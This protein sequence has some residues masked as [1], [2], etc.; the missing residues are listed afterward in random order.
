MKPE[1]LAIHAGYEIDSTTGAIT[2]PIHLSTTFERDLDGG[3][4]RGFVYTRDDNPNRLELERRLAALEN[5]TKA[6]A[7]A[8]SSAAFMSILQALKAGDHVIAPN[9]MYFGIQVILRE[10]F[11]DWNL[12]AS[13][14]KAAHL[15]EIQAAV[16]PNTKL[17]LIETP[18]NP[19]I[20]LTDIRGASNIAHEV[21]ALLLVDNTIASPI[22]Q[23]PFEHGAD[24]VVHA[25]TKYL[26]GHSDVLGGV[27]I[28]KEDSEFGQKL[29]RIQKIGGAVPSPFDCYLLM[30]GIFSLP[31]R[32]RAINDNALQVA[33]FLTT[34]PKIETV[35]HVGLEHHPH[36]ELGLRQ[37]SGYGGLFSFLVKGGQNEAMAITNNLK[38][39]KRATS[40]GGVHTTI[41]HRASIETGTSTPQNLLRISLGL[42]HPDDLIEDL[43]QAL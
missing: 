22:F 23:R 30:R 35:L 14:V 40:F 3:F 25:T 9:D 15:D 19:Q 12:Q 13:F 24:I 21:G 29:E 41:E 5:G 1:T 39:I 42:E 4:S 27:A 38:L 20:N 37:M 10:I 2:P 36:Y 7:F 11:A 33:K 18:S 26:G 16:R 43:A 28:L 34:H 6:L 8:S 31:Y 32:M 17:I